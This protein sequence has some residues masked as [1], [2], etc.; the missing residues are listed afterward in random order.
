L[1]AKIEALEPADGWDG[2]RRPKKDVDAGRAGGGLG[3]RVAGGGVGRCEGG[4]AGQRGAC[5][6]AGVMSQV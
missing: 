4:G 6:G 5:V 3:F 1:E 2:A